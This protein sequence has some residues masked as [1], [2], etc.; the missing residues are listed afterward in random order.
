MGNT[1]GNYLISATITP[2]S[3]GA[4][5]TASQTF[6][7]PG[8]RTTDFVDVTGPAPTAGTGIV[9]SRVSAA[10]TLQIDFINATA[11]SLTPVSGSYGITLA[12][13]ASIPVPLTIGD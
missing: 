12:R 5:T 8:L 11:G 9:G 4:A 13:P 6:T 1:F 2:A 10:N 7:I 3:V